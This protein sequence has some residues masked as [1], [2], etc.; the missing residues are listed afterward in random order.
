[1]THKKIKIGTGH[2]LSVKN[3]IQAFNE[4]ELVLSNMAK[5][6]IQKS[7]QFLEKKIQSREVIYGINTQFGDQ[8]SHADHLLNSQNEEAYF[9]SLKARQYH[10]VKSHYAGLGPEVDPKAVRLTMLLRAHSIAQGYSGVTLP[11]VEK[12]LHWF[13]DDITPVVYQYGSIGASGDLIPLAT[14][15]AA[16]IGEPVKIRVKGIEKLASELTEPAHELCVREGL[17]LINGTSFMTAI[18]TIAFS[19]LERLVRQMIDIIGMTLEVLYVNSDHYEPLLQQLKGHPGSIMVCE[20]LKPF[21][22]MPDQ[23]KPYMLQNYYSLRSVCQGF[24]PLVDNLEHARVM[25]EHEINAVT[26]N[27]IVDPK[28][29]RILHGANFMGHYITSAADLLKMDIAQASTW[30]HAILA[31]LYHPRKN[32]DLPT[33]LLEDPATFNGFRPLQL[34]A[35]SIAVENRKLAQS[36]QA[37]MLPTEGDNQD[38]NSLG[39]HAALDLQKVTENL[40]RL[41]AILY[42][43]AAQAWEYRDQNTMSAVSRKLYKKLRKVV[44][45]R[46]EDGL[47]TPELEKV[48][49]LLQE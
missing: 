5:K 35:A 14:I 19:H 47:F 22:N 32:A 38:V 30:V 6:K 29:K 10:L 39:T 7:A 26:D 17:A 34:L 8:M 12:L 27:P 25:I 2:M 49:A 24:G 15:A 20:W 44:P 16:L 23:K 4:T 46:K 9:G 33:N 37:F 43:S 13:H 11:L 42:L 40:E 48:I 45:A 31:V 36:H 41:V 3:C 1:M 21:F 28:N 18:A